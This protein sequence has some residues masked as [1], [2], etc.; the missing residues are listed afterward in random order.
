MIAN[1]S[2][3]KKIS[4]T[5]NQFFQ[6]GKVP[7]DMAGGCKSVKLYLKNNQKQKKE[8]GHG[9]NGRA[10][11]QQVQGPEFNSPVLK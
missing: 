2:L 8:W 10:L 11:I 1:F 7:C 9:S 5:S 3:D 6:T 4:R